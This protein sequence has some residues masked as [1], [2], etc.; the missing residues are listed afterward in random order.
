[1]CTH[2]SAVILSTKE[3]S[4]RSDLPTAHSAL[5][6]YLTAAAAHQ[7]SHSAAG[8]PSASSTLARSFGNGSPSLHAFSLGKSLPFFIILISSSDSSELLRK[9]AFVTT[10]QVA[11]S[12]SDSLALENSNRSRSVAWISFSHYPVLGW[13]SPLPT[14][15]GWAGS[16]TCVSADKVGFCVAYYAS[17]LF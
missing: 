1:M 5:D 9:V 3:P 4:G 6:R 12:R 2:S 11:E 14:K 8:E 17:P 15:E 16:R 13:L 7:T 10:G